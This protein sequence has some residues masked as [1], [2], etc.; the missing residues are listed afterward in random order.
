MVDNAKISN[1]LVDDMETES[2]HSRKRPISNYF[3]HTIMTVNCLH[4]AA[5]GVVPTTR[6]N[7]VSDEH[8]TP[9]G[10]E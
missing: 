6:C 4:C 8:N 10:V 5:S 1:A 9:S 3:S 7:C 2:D